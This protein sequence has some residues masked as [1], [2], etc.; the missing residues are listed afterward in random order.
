MVKFKVKAKSGKVTRTETVSTTGKNSI[1]R[2][3]KTSSGIKKKY[4]NYWGGKVKVLKVSRVR[5]RSKS[6]WSF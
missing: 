4:Q 5:K 2:G 1:F 6:M 3:V